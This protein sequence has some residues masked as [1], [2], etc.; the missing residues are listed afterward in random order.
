MGDSQKALAYYEQAL[1]LQQAVGDRG[2]EAVTLN[3]IAMVYY[4][5]GD[6]ETELF[7]YERSL[8]LTIAVQDPSGEATTRANMAGTL[9][10][11]GRRSEALRHMQIARDLNARIGISTEDEDYYLAQWRA[12]LGLPGGDDAR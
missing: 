8:P 11:L 1:P 12:E 2:G 9:W 4:A 10:T 6:S 3:N 7:Y 5:L